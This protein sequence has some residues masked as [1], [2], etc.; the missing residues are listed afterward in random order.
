MKKPP[1]DEL[2]SITE[3]IIHFFILGVIV[4]LGRKAESK[5][6]EIRLPKPFGSLD[7]TFCVWAIYVV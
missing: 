6:K 3:L 7:E 2:E 5:Y 1:Y 4:H